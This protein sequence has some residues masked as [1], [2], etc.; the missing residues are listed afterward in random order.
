MN[1]VEQFKQQEFRLKKFYWIVDKNGQKQL[2]HPNKI[3]QKINECKAKRKII[4]KSR[5][6]GVSTNELIK[7]FDK[8]IWTPN[9]TSCILAHEQDG[10]EKLFRIVRRAHTYMDPRIQPVLDR[11]GGSKYEMFFPA[12]N[13]R[14][15]VDLESRGDTIH[16][17]HIS[18]MAFIKELKRAQATIESVPING[19]IT[20]EST[21]NGLNHFYED[22]MDTASPYE[23]LFYPWFM[24]DEYAIENNELT[25]AHLTADEK[26]FIIKS[27][28]S[29]NVDISF[30]QIAFRRF[31]QSSLKGLFQQ[32]YPEDD[33]TC[34]LTSGNSPFNL[35]IIKEL[36]EKCK[37]PIDVVNG[38]RIY[39]QFIPQETYVIAG[40]PAEGIGGDS[41]AAHVFKVR[42]RE[43]VAA[44]H[45]N[46]LKPSEFADK[47]IEMAE[48]YG[49]KY[50]PPLIGV[51]R[52][53]HG[54]AVLLKLDEVINYAN[55][56]RHDQDNEEKLGWITDRVTRPLMLDTFIEGVENGTIILRDK[57]TLAECLTLV[58]KEGKIEAEDGKH[59]DLVI[60]GAIGVQMCI[61][62]SQSDIYSSI[63]GKILV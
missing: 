46:N 2:L 24:H 27:K 30:A 28:E 32:E 35:P 51:E 43:Q 39:Q 29:Y 4:L 58:N 47:L 37:E 7:I 62:E 40:D 23:K 19:N 44:F 21:P 9:T 14:I 59:D 55:I 36:Y 8:T 5:Q 12:I 33:S 13:S 42:N 48:M 41:S 20:V 6:V 17:L 56:F 45:A 50:P 53:N 49:V 57:Q 3:Q 1:D 25:E 11:G 34:F 31:K 15:Y 63:S 60:A 16:N 38:I 52:N 18:E 61:E 10:I 54:H 22:W 26:A